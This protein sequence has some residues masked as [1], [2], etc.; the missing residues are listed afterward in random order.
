MRTKADDTESILHSRETIQFAKRRK[1]KYAPVSCAFYDPQPG[2]HSKQSKLVYTSC[3]LCLLEYAKFKPMWDCAR[4]E[5]D[6]VS[7]FYLESK[8]SGV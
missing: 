8:S 5:Q 7:D 1:I 6:R 4:G 3:T 2:A